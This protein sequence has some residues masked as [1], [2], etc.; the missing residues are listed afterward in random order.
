MLDHVLRIGQGQ[1]QPLVDGREKHEIPVVHHV[2]DRT[3]VVLPAQPHDHGMRGKGKG[4]QLLRVLAQHARIFQRRRLGVERMDQPPRRVGP[5]DDHARVG[6]GE[7]VELEHPD[8]AAGAHQRQDGGVVQAFGAVKHAGFEEPVAIGRRP[9]EQRGRP[10]PGRQCRGQIVFLARQAVDQQKGEVMCPARL[11]GGQRATRRDRAVDRLVR[12]HR[13]Q[14]GDH[15]RRGGK[16]P[17][18]QAHGDHRALGITLGADFTRC[19]AADQGGGCDARGKVRGKTTG[20]R[21]VGEQ[22]DKGKGT[23]P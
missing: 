5:G 12:V 20:C 21:G 2:A 13:A 6:R 10:Q 3:D 8:R 22:D 7:M 14:I 1:H 17:G 11:C 15:Q 4:R 18:G 23:G 19:C 9:P 16:V